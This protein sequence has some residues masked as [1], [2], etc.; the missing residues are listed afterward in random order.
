[1]NIYD[2]ELLL[3]L[4]ID[5]PHGTIGLIF[6]ESQEQITVNVVNHFN[7]KERWMNSKYFLKQIQKFN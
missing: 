7:G 5:L 4:F 6:H 2:E 1:M 3:L